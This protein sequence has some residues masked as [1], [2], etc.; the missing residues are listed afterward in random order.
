VKRSAY[1]IQ[2]LTACGFPV[3][4]ESIIA[5]V[6]WAES[7]RSHLLPPTGAEWNPFDTENPWANAT[8]FNTVG[9]KNYATVD[10]GIAATKA[11]VFNGYYPNVVAAFKTKQ[12]ANLICQ[13]VT[14]SPWGSKPTDALVNAVRANMALYDVEINPPDAA[15]VPPAPVP[16]QPPT[17]VDMPLSDADKAWISVNTQQHLAD[18]YN[19]EWGPEGASVTLSSINDRLG[20]IETKL[21]M[22]VGRISWPTGKVPPA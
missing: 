9:V 21:G 4:N 8:D 11:T 13:A 5:C 10:D 3:V 12:T 7:E 17:E 16:D 14:R 15:P 6:A 1:A 2:W 22:S 18:F 19:R 20:A